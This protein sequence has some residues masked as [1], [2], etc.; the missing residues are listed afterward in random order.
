[1]AILKQIYEIV[2]E[3]REK[4]KLLHDMSDAWNGNDPFEAA[5]SDPG[6]QY[7]VGREIDQLVDDLRKLLCKSGD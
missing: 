1:M 3:I 5:M 4:D 6:L 7:E 2:D